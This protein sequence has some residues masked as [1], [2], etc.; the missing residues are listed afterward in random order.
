LG[1]APA[2]THE[3]DALIK[4]LRAR[5]AAAAAE[6]APPIRV[7]IVNAEELAPKD[8]IVRM[9][10]DRSGKLTGAVAHKL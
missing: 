6:P 8:T 3:I 7:E 10:R 9:E 2:Q 1:F 5:K 4:I